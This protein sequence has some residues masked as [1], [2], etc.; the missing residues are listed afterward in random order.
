MKEVLCDELWEV[1]KAVRILKTAVRYAHTS[2]CLTASTI[3]Y[4]PEDLTKFRASASAPTRYD[5]IPIRQ[6]LGSLP[7]RIPQG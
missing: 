2:Y 3:N 7:T 1:F 4:S 6:F 5:D